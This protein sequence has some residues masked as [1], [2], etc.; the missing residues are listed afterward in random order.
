[1]IKRFEVPR[2]TDQQAEEMEITNWIWNS[3][4]WDEYAPGYYQC[5]WCLAQHTSYTGVSAQYPLCKENPVI[6]K[7][8]QT[9]KQET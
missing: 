4:F 1:M 7:L 3:H 9:A 8:L 5:R 2:L 6:K